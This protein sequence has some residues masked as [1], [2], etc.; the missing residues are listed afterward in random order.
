MTAEPTKV[1]VARNLLDDAIR[2]LEEALREASKERIAADPEDDYG[3]EIM[4]DCILSSWVL[5]YYWSGPLDHGDV[6]G[7]TSIMRGPGVPVPMADGLFWSA[8]NM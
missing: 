5:V 2:A 1:E 7:H 8:L 4:D 6:E 3:P